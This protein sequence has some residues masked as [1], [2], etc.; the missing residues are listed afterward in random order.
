MK[1]ARVM[2]WC[3]IVVSVGLLSL[4]G[5]GDAVAAVANDSILSQHFKEADGTSGQNTNSGSGVKTGH[6]QDGAVTT[7]K[8]AAGAVVNSSIAAGH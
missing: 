1:M 8:I 5:V 3:V 4:A 2:F 7:G 6:I